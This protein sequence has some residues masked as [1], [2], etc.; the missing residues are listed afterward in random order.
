MSFDDG[1]YFRHRTD[2]HLAKAGECGFGTASVHRRFAELYL[3]QAAIADQSGRGWPAQ[4]TG[5][6]RLGAQP[7]A[8]RPIASGAAAPLM[9]AA[10]RR[11]A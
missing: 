6:P 8:S 1:S 2:V 10:A 4:A 11:E 3:E 9:P 7:A 5:W